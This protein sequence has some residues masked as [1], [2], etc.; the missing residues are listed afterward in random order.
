[1]MQEV[2][3]FSASTEALTHDA[4][5]SCHNLEILTTSGRATTR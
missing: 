3:G 1:L 2:P 4:I 5:V